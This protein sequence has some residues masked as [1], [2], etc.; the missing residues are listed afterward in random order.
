MKIHNPIYTIFALLM[1]GYVAVA[2]H[3]GWSLVQSVA[4]H[5]WPRGYP[6]TQHK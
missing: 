1:A 6:S 3:N 5:A 4:R 2:N